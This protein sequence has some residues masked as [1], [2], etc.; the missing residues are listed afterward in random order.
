MAEIVSEAATEI[1]P[2]YRVEVALGVDPSVV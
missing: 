1:G 2:A